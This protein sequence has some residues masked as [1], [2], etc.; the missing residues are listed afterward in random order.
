[1]SSGAK[2]DLL[3]IILVR[4]L[5][6][7]SLDDEKADGVLEHDV[8][9]KINGHIQSVINQLDKT[10]NAIP[11]GLM[12]TIQ[13][14]ITIRL[15][16][17]MKPLLIKLSQHEVQLEIFALY[18]LQVNFEQRPVLLDIYKWYQNPNNYFDGIDLILECGITE[19][20]NGN[21]YQLAIK[22]IQEIR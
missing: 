16:Y 9:E 4:G 6:Q 17:T 18:L 2:R 11:K 3:I 14:W 5:L 21:M 7:V 15:D 20:Q 13:K 1:M 19:D 10:M 12:V 8:N 22:T